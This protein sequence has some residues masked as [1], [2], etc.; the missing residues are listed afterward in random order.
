[1]ANWNL[2]VDLHGQGDDLA[3]ALRESATEARSL[4]R[5]VRTAER[6]VTS[7]GRTARTTGSHLGHL[8]R[9]ARTVSRDLQR[10]ARA[11]RETDA[12]LRRIDRDIQVR[13]RV[14]DDITP[15][16]A[17]ARRVLATVRAAAQ[18]TSW[19]LHILE[20]RAH[21]TA[22]AFNDLTSSALTASGALHTVARSAS[23]AD[24][25]LRT[26]S[27][28]TRTLRTDMDDLDATVGRIHGRL[29]SL[30]G[31][32]AGM[33]SSTGHTSR[34]T[35]NMIGAIIGLSAAL[36]PVAAA[37]T[38][39][40]AGMVAA[41][42]AVGAYGLAI[43]GQ[44]VAMT[45][46]SEAQDKYDKAVREHGKHSAEAAKAEAEYQRLVADMPPA[47]R[48]AAA[49]LSAL[50]D[51]YGDWSDALAADTMPVVT[52][53]MG[54]FGAMLPRLTPL[55]QGT[56]RELERL[57]AVAAG[58]MQTPGFDR[59]MDR[60]TEFATDSLARA[61]SGLV[62]F[63]QAMNTGEIGGNLREFLDFAR[64]NAPLVGE[65]LG[66]LAQALLNLLVA[67]SDMGVG[68]LTAVNVLAQLINAVPPE[69]L[70]VF[71][72]LYA[73]FK[74]VALGM[75]A[76]GAVAGGSAA[77]ALAGFVRSARFAGV[78]PAI[79]GVTQRMSG[80]QKAAAG[81]GVLGIAAIA[82]DMLAEKSR[83]APPDVDKLAASLKALSASSGGEFSGE[84]RKT[85]GDMDGFVAKARQMGAESKL[86]E[87]AKPWTAFS[88][89]GPLADPVISKMDDLI[90]GTK[91][92]GATKD[93]L[94]SFDEAF[95]DLATSG[96][97][98]VAAQQFKQFDA[99]LR[100][101]GKSTK[102]INALFPEYQQALAGL[103]AEQE[104]AAAGMG[105]FGEQAQATQSK[106]DAQKASADGL[107][108]S[109]VALNDANR[110]GLG[111][112]IGFEAALDAAANSARANA[113]ALEMNGGKLNLNSERAR[114]AA[115][116]LNDLAAKTDEAAGAARESGASWETVNGIY[117]RG[118][119]ALV[120]AAMQ[121]G[122]TS[123]QA[124]S[125]AASILQIPDKST[126]TIEMRREDAIAGLN[127]VIAKIQATP[128]SKSVT[129]KALTAD[130][131][132]TLESLGYKVKTLPNGKV[133]VTARTGS[134][135]SGLY[136]VKQARD[137]LRD[138]TI[139]IT[140]HY[141]VT[142]STARTPRGQGSQL[143][144]ADGGIADYYADGGIR[145]SSTQRGGVRH[146]AAGAE[147]HIAQ[148]AP[149]GSW[150]VW[151]EPETGG[152]SYIPLAESKRPRSR[153][154]AEET[155]RRLG[156]NPAD[157]QWRAN[158]DVTDWR[159]D[160]QTGSLY[161]ASEAGQA[162]HK[163]KKVKVKGKNG[164][165]TTKDVD[166]FSISAVESKIKSAAK[167]TRSWNKD[168]EKV[169]DRVGGDVAE[170][171]AGMGKDGVALAKKMANGSKKYTEEMAKALRDLNK[172]TQA[173]LTDYT[174]QLNNSN[175]ID[176]TFAKNLATLAGQ[177]Y[178]ELAAQLAA[179]N[180]EAAHD[181]AASA[182][183]DKKK[184]SS[185]NSAAK[186]ANNALT[187]DQVQDLVAIIAAVKTSKTGIHDVAATT[188][189]GEDEI[190]D[191][192]LKA[193]SQIVSA[194]GS[195]ASR[196]IADLKKAS[197]GMAY[198]NGG[199]RAGLYSTQGGAVT[200]AEPSTG[201]EAYIPLGATKRRSAL[202][203]LTDVAG[204]FGLGLTNAR[205]SRV[206][207]I[208]EQGPLIG[209]QTWQI[210]SGG[211][212]ADTARRV[213]A[214]N[215]YQLR[216]LSRGGVGAR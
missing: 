102:E 46:A 24:T 29:G 190:I 185:A 61:T 113:G 191:V 18:D 146:F 7:L 209:S 82:I 120:S 131:R 72:Q 84:L 62:R 187:A 13:I 105:V 69:A 145:G 66:N 95:A 98:D 192:A 194:L 109:I 1:M 104:L 200:F 160:P 134:A 21:A 54:L 34:N 162:G 77:A 88:G 26:V 15:A 215:A 14:D 137:A 216:R 188:G 70:S 45:E 25:S 65:T 149:A 107:R 143:K 37:I 140:T 55:V 186:T 43:G 156:G 122:L 179:Q 47:T 89:L 150:R 169:A 136:A 202:P 177:G 4:A 203:V 5:D 135:L 41:G 108:Q 19:A 199:I 86:L 128:G 103:K 94:K 180:D 83:G 127:S 184:A 3:R 208:R 189:L 173:S 35:R 158:G 76:M 73:A 23:S 183:K 204:R 80:L 155:V 201:G 38:P 92:L 52:Q 11:A 197:T 138:R 12:A 100:A 74:L 142:G 166:Y 64:A 9:Q 2:S 195:R 114:T 148:I 68:I 119:D 8:S 170:A 152:E 16:A 78:G 116:A 123:G 154:I 168:L 97:A 22:N 172:A 129:V 59:F 159:Y 117:G 71:L 196:F 60:F 31:Q 175:K 211:S 57:L 174:R 164:K 167:A 51:E 126:T 198:E 139:T 111:G 141:R 63:T 30:N 32:L 28:S 85:F 121:M 178:G 33:S 212:A 17:A 106:L 132:S 93:D 75:A 91:S 144:Y 44:I 42:A 58:G 207:V 206:V 90:R 171:L 181:L 6:N 115:T 161:S 214:D 151:G 39:I 40:A 163:T 27:S 210:T 213:D 133:Q 125:L 118:R 112:M 50:K 10:V 157:I 110:S 36:I 99:A 20:R 193:K 56:S 79:T 124:K 87:Q 182:V 53:S 176:A 165:Y 67:A 81:L 153:A 205:D 130:A 96:H 147:N 49:A 48:E 101:S